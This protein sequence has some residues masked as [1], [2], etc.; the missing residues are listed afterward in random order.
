MSLYQNPIYQSDLRRAQENTVRFEELKDSSVLITGATGLIG[1]FLVEMLMLSNKEKNTNIRVYAMGRSMSRLQ[2]RFQECEDANLVLVENDV[3]E[4]ISF[5]EA[6]D[7]I[8]HA[9]SNAFPAAFQKDPVGT[10]MSN[11][12]G[13]HNLLEYGRIHNCK[14]FLFVSS[15]EVYGQ[16]D[17]SLDGFSE[18]YSGYVDPVQVRSCYPMS[19]RMAETLCASYTQQYGLDTV[20][21]RPCHTYGP[22]ATSADNRANV[23][24]VNDALSGK[25][26]VLKSKGEQ[27][28]SYCYIAD[29]ASALLTVLLWGES[30]N[31]YNLANENV[32]VSIAGFAKEVAKQAGRRVI[33]DIPEEVDKMAT[34]IQKQVLLVNKL[35]ELGWHGA[36]SLETGIEHIMSILKN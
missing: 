28:R 25:D 26:I 34:P 32:Q 24:F 16:G 1:S 12:Q 2:E 13:T 6:V 20:I 15:G 19:K 3:N 35:N 10:I 18:E 31:A 8:I 7:Y 29:C 27:V 21:V 9:A 22:N 23:Q 33:F 30:A 5:E 11:V 17:L 14:R 4:E 36:F